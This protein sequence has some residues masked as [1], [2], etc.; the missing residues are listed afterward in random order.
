MQGPP[1]NTILRFVRD[2]AVAE[3]VRNLTDGEYPAPRS[4]APPSARLKTAF[5]AKQHRPD[6]RPLVL[7][8]DSWSAGYLPRGPGEGGDT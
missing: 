8:V 1:A 6:A 3:G 2:R 5:L 4:G 7:Q